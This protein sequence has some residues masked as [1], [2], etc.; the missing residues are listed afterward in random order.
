MQPSVDAGRRFGQELD[1]NLH[2]VRVEG[3]YYLM[4]PP[5]LESTD[6]DIETEFETPEFET[7]ELQTTE[8]DNKTTDVGIPTT[9][10][11]D[12]TPV[13][14]IDSAYV[15]IPTPRMPHNAFI[16]GDS[17]WPA[18]KEDVSPVPA[19]PPPGC[20]VTPEDL[21]PN[22]NH[23]ICFCKQP[24]K[25]GIVRIVQCKNTECFIR[26]YHYA[27]LK[28]RKEKGVARFG[29]LLCEL[30]KGE[31]YWGK[32]QGETD[33]SMPFSQKEVLDGI[34]SMIGGSGGA[35]PYGLGDRKVHNTANELDELD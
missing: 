1:R 26:W 22:P 23:L 35:N 29:T 34:M 20:K 12:E 27:C 28:D 18:L 5:D 24:A 32:T 30:C 25:T 2:N 8:S 13:F 9:G 11:D 6:A 14:D 15:L 4:P 31:E 33:L 19:R 3:S 10:P 7:P 17:I 16:L 21:Y